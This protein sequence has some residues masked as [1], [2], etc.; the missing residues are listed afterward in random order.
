VYLLYLAFRHFRAGVGAAE[1]RARS[2]SDSALRLFLHTYLVTALNPK[3]IMFFVAFLPQFVDPAA[4]ATH[5][6]AVLAVTFVTMAAGN[7]AMYSTFAAGAAR[8]LASPSTGRP[9]NLTAGALLGGAGI[10]ALL[11][12]HST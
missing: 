2:V 12:R 4:D 5:Q 7:A 6:L 8:L 9:L 11:A 10:W 1:L 3:S